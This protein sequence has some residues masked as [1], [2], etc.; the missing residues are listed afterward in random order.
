VLGSFTIAQLNTAVNDA[1]VAKVD[2][3]IHTGAHAFS[4]TIRPTSSGS[5]TP[6]ATSLMKRDDE[7]TRMALNYLRG[8]YLWSNK[9]TDYTANN[10][11]T[12]SN[13]T[14]ID[15]IDLSTGATASSVS[16][17]R[18][19]IF[20]FRV[21]HLSLGTGRGIVS[22]SQRTIYN[23]RIVVSDITG[24]DTVVRF[25]LGQ[26]YTNTTAQDLTSA[27]RGIGFKIIAGL[28][29]VQV[30]NTTTL[31]TTSTSTT[32]V[33]VREYDLTLDADGA[34]NWVA[35][36][37]GANVASGIGAP[38]GNSTAGNNA[39]CMSLTNGT[40]AANRQLYVVKQSTLQIP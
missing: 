5:G 29:Y 28:V 40:T 1:D 38:T 37:N 11:G 35:Y 19:N 25:L 26:V 9:H 22:W 2:A 12:G 8:L 34:G 15:V 13:S 7:D 23:L 39:L 32:I 17:L 36:I 4:S 21:W 20:H 18:S 6:D 30:A 33:G 3:Q 16:L 24:S 10:V 31:T 14:N 27:D